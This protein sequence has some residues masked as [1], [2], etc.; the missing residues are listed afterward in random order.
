MTMKNHRFKRI[1][2]LILVAA[3]LAG[4]YVPGAQA[5]STGLSW[6]ETDQPIRHDLSHREVEKKDEPTHQPGDVVRVSIVLEDKPTIQ[7]GFGTRDIAGN[8][9]AL[10]YGN[11]LKA[12]QDDLAAAISSQVLGGRKLDVV[13]NLTLAANLISARIPYGHIDTIA[14]MDGVKAVILENRYEPCVV[15]REDVAQPQ[16][17][18]SLG[19]TGSSLTWGAGYTG[20]GSRVAVVDTGTDTDHQSLDNGAFLYALEQNAAAAGMSFEEYVAGLDLLDAQEI[21]SVLSY[22][23]IAKRIDSLSAEDLYLNEKL[24]FAANYVDSNLIVDHESDYQG[25]H[26]SHVAGIAAANRYIPSG[27]GYADALQTVFMAG[28]A[29]D[30]QLIT[31]KV[32]GEGSPYDSDYM[33]AVEDAIYLNCDAVNLSLGTS[34]AG[35]T[36]N[37]YFSELLEYMA[38]TDT[39]VVAS[40]GNSYSWPTASLHG[41]LYY[42]DVNFD[43]VGSPGS[44]SNFFTVAS[45][46]NDGGVGTAFRVAG[47][48][49]LYGEVTGYGNTALVTLD[50]SANSTGTDYDYVF[51][52][53]LGNPEDYAGMD[54]NG[55]VVFCSRGTLNFAV[56]ANNAMALG[57]KAVIIYNNSPDG[58][59]GMDLTGISY[60]RPCVSISQ[61]DADTVR[62]ASAKQTTAEGLTYYTG[63]ITILGK[64]TGFQSNSEYY[65]MSDFS[66]WGVP[67]TLELKPEITAPG[68]NIY[69]LWGTNTVSGGGT[70][71]YEMMSGTSMAAPA[72]TG[73]AALVAQYLRE[74]GLAEQ[75]GMQVRHL[76]Q[77][78]LMSTA[79]PLFEEASGGQYYSLM[80]QGAGMAR[81]DL[82]IAADSYILVDG[83]TDGKVKAELGDDPGRKG[84]YSFSF[85]INNLT[86]EAQNYLLRADVFRQDMFEYQ[87]GTEIFLLDTWTTDLPAVAAF[88]VNGVP[89]T[90]D[91][92][93][94]KYDLNGDGTTNALDADYLLEYLLG[95]ETRLYGEGD[96]SGDGATNTY[97]A[98]VLLALLESGAPG[99]VNLP[100]GGSVTVDVTLTL[101]AEGKKILEDNYPNGTYVEAFVYAE[102]VSDEEGIAG[103]VHSIPVLAFYGNWSDPSMYD[104]GTLLDLVYLTSNVAPYLY[105][106]VGPYG[107]ALSIDYGNGSEYYFG[108]NPYLDDATYLP[109]RNAFN[110]EDRSVL[111][112]QSF[113]LIRNATAGSLVVSNAETGEEYMVKTMGELYS[114]VF[115]PNHGDWLNSIQYAGL[116]WKGTDASGNPV[117][118]DTLVN[119]TLTTIPEYYRNA[120]GTHN[121]DNLGKGTDL[122][123][124]FYIDNTA[125]TAL[126]IEQI[127]ENTLAVTVQDNRYVAAVALLNASGTSLLAIESPNQTEKGVSTTMELDLTGLMGKSFLLLVGDYAMNETVYEITLELPEIERDYFTAI[128]YSTM[129]YVSMNTSGEVTHLIST[130]LPLMARAAEYVGGYVFIITEDNSLCVANDEDLS[131]THRI[132]QLDPDSQLLITGFNDMAYNHAD[133]KLYGQFYS[134]F[135]YESTPYLCT[136]DMTDGTIEVVCELPVDVNTMAIDTDGNFYSAGYNSNILY[137]YTLADVT[138]DNPAM[139]IVGEMGYYYSAYLTNMA[140]DHNTDKLY[141]AFPN[142][143][144]EIDPK[145]AEPTLLGYHQ[146]LLVGLYT[147]PQ[148]DEGMFDPVDTVDR[149]E[150]NFTET[151]VL[152]NNTLTLEATVWPWNASDRTV[153]WTSSNPAVAAVDANGLIT[154]KALGSVVITATSNLDP[155]KTASCTVTVENVPSKKLNAIVW[156]DA[157]EI[158]MSEFYTDKLP[159]Y[160]K[161][162]SDGLGLDLAAATVNEEGIIYAASLDVN[163]LTSDLYKLDPATFE[164]TLIGPSTDGYMDLAPAPGQK[165]NS[166][167]AVY[168]GNVL[169][170]DADTGDYYNHYYM[171]SYNL[172]ALAYVGTQ[173]YTDWGYDTMVDWYF[174]IDRVGN[175]YLMGFLEQDG[176]YYYLEHDQLAPGGIYT[177]LDFE[178]ETAYFG[179]AYF[180]GEYLYFSAYKQSTDNVTLMAIDVA[181]GSKRC[182][183][184]GTFDPGVWPVAG[185]MELGL[186]D[187]PT[188]MSAP[189]SAK[190]Q[191]SDNT[192]ELSSLALG[193]KEAQAASGSLNTSVAPASSGEYEEQEQ[194]VVVTLTGANSR[195][196]S[197]NG[198]MTLT[199]DPDA[200]KLISV[201]GTTEAFAYTMGNGTV[202]VAYASADL[203]AADAPV[204]TLTFEILKSGEHELVVRHHECDNEPSGKE[205]ILT[206]EVPGEEAEDVIWK[207]ATTSLNGTIDLNV[208]VQLSDALVNNPATFVRF[209]YAN[210]V[211]DVPIADAVISEKDGITRYRFSCPMYAKEVSE[212]VTIQV[213]Q[214]DKVFGK[215][216]EYSI[217]TYCMNR[218]EKSTNAAQV[219]LCKALLNYASAAQ[220]SFNYK[221]DQLANAGLSEADKA[222]PQDIDVSRYASSIVGSETG[223]KPKSATLMLENVVSVRVYFTLEEGYDITD[224]TFTIDGKVVQPQKNSI[225]WFIETNG[226]AAKNLDQMFAF[227]VGGLT[228]NYG[229]MSYVNSKLDASNTDTANLSRALYAYYQ[230]AE[231][232][233]G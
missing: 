73:M 180:D 97:D 36:Y 223:I 211:V 222:L 96:V 59:F 7:A 153:T 199:Y 182:Y 225:G 172:V 94:S 28:V 70:D 108:G 2:S 86:D 151:R 79:E 48:A 164:P 56:K 57:A 132:C 220:L 83:Q 90:Q 35:M 24:P 185:L 43:T 187:L 65:T 214:G 99:S 147:R 120:D 101:T 1:L 127:D 202:E 196:G 138:S 118:E 178:M 49:M 82:A 114:T 190:P 11:S 20:A 208:Y 119:V 159:N 193:E 26:G 60:A 84:V 206:V 181:G 33:A 8:A 14:Q 137:T 141:W 167:M 204:A 156:D 203:L 166:L 22:L 88:T 13:W 157:G 134:Q 54:L 210:K 102:E 113:S 30:A 121:V 129:D 78:L 231:A 62:S 191:T 226:I 146:E 218:I 29:P 5:A 64:P 85:T 93:L 69:S 107:N 217:V 23:N 15:E 131:A 18:A 74:T 72:I 115:S 4:F 100:A 158:W 171:F 10:A 34:T 148:E 63:K 205:E 41:Y 177:T 216:L 201:T 44:H 37:P 176:Y 104:R 31:M 109:Q 27:T 135:N 98:H 66:S 136:I 219:A 6:K 61:Q 12:K 144:V 25:E 16:M 39:V 53:G 87:E 228:V 198:R 92:S 122:T 192:A 130:G 91:G 17:Y 80:N 68:G 77:S 58:V 213:M 174:I 81:V 168:G 189:N 207:S 188:F 139:T 55:K 75:E 175:V 145:T 149:V 112:D 52:D 38:K 161:L 221:T 142:T 71:Q 143:L 233:L 110:S 3:L 200:L 179:S 125:P 46:E 154:A 42:D 229:P 173:E 209:Q 45:V 184:L 116:N 140:W 89:M 169:M 51:I 19:M 165:G 155:T 186:S 170:V 230:A 123:T 103:T 232:L 95:N 126:K 183:T 40:A 194:Q 150:L 50:T 106:Y 162:H 215:A 128:D 32:F 21:A 195:S 160:T 212:K 9:E 111:V 76:A 227:S 152:V 197:T 124:Q 67:G 163:D 47:T 105:R 117:A 133:G 224:F